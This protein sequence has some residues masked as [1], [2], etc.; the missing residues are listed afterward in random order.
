VIFIGV[1]VLKFDAAFQIQSLQYTNQQADLPLQTNTL[2]EVPFQK[3][4]CKILIDRGFQ[5]LMID[6]LL[7]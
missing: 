4:R 1:S 6:L 5:L 2:V 7:I 3:L